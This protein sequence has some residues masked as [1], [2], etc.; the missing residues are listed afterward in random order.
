MKR[1][2]IAGST[3]G[4]APQ[5]IR[6]VLAAAAALVFASCASGYKSFYTPADGATPEAIAARRAAPPPD[7]PILERS[8]P[9]KPEAV[10]AAY[11]KRGYAMIGASS[12]SSGTRQSEASALQQARAVRAD[13]VLVL[14]PQYAGAVTSSIPITT[15]TTTT[16]HTTG[17]ATAGSTLAPRRL[18]G[19][20][21]R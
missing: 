10:L 21:V 16:A 9:D 15:P 17:S 2:A 3:R 11:A 1:L 14:N 5:T 4:S 7:S 18:G 19:K 6:Q 12:F 20:S 13:L 8:A